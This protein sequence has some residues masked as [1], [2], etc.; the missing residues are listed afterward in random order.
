MKYG[1][2]LFPTTY[3]RISGKGKTAPKEMALQSLLLKMDV[4]E[5]IS[6]ITMLF[7][8]AGMIAITP[9]LTTTIVD[10]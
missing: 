1:L 7:Q 9:E 6:I 5:T 10:S 8:Y 2:L 4:A 3:Y